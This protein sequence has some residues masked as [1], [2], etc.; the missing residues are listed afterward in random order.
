VQIHHPKV[1]KP[2]LKIHSLKAIQI[3]HGQNFYI[4][5]NGR[6]LT[7]LRCLVSRIHFGHFFQTATGFQKMDF[8][9][10]NRYLVIQF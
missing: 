1:H 9:G 7:I 2:K 10:K 8:I 5:R 3:T 6:N 4:V